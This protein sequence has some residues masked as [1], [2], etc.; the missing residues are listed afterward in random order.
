MSGRS[1]G[2]LFLAAVVLSGCGGRATPATSVAEPGP[3]SHPSGITDGEYFGWV[4]GIEDGAIRFDP[5]ELLTGEEASRAALED[6]FIGDGDPLPNDFYIRDPAVDT[7]T[8]PLAA[9]ASYRLLLFVD[10]APEETEVSLE[11]VVGALTG[12]NPDVYGV[13]GGEFPATI[14]VERGEVTAIVQ[15][16]LP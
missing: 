6:G 14:T 9:G 8:V 1:L 4:E 10:G 11:E 5:A 12:H 3:S 16:Y 7:I 13:A 15:T 2:A